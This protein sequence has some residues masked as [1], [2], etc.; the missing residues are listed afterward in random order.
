MSSPLTAAAPHMPRRQRS[1]RQQQ[2]IQERLGQITEQ[3]LHHGRLQRVSDRFGDRA[4]HARRRPLGYS[5]LRFQCQA[6]PMLHTGCVLFFITAVI[7]GLL[8][9]HDGAPLGLSLPGSVAKSAAVHHQT[10]P[11]PGPAMWGGLEASA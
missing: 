6:K 1:L 8:V 10:A 4:L 5:A 9:G 3:R 7:N 2:P 11:Q